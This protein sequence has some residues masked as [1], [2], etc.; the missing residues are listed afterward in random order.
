MK[1]GQMDMMAPA[2]IK[3]DL[4]LVERTDVPW[5]SF[6]FA[7]T[8]Q[9]STR[10]SSFTGYAS[11]PVKWFNILVEAAKLRMVMQPLVRQA[12]LKQG[13]AQGVMQIHDKYVTPADWTAS[14]AEYTTANTAIVPTTMDTFDGVV[15]DPEDEHYAINLTNKALRRNAND[16][17]RDAR[18]ELTERLSYVIDDAIFTAIRP[19]SGG[20]VT[21]MSN[22]AQGCQ[23]IFGGSATTAGDSL[24]VGDTLTTKMIRKS[25]KLLNTS[26]GRYWTS[27][28]FT[29]SAVAKNP[30]S[31]TP[32]GKYFA[33]ISS[34]DEEALTGQSQFNNA[35][36]F[37]DDKIVKEGYIGK[38]HGFDFVVSDL[39]ANYSSG[40]DVYVQGANT[41]VD[42]DCHEVYFVKA[43]YFAGLMWGLQPKWYVFD[44]P[45]QYQKNIQTEMAYKA[46][47]LHSDA[48]VR[49]IVADQ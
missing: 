8:Q 43:N 6:E 23:T 13:E 9:S 24:N 31:N 46:K 17:V 11:E 34:D 37:G 47:P 27:D 26:K 22:T 40:D 38:F 10:G 49:A 48:I 18:I 1:G 41:S 33:I 21:E 12:T 44:N 4:Q 42:I 3:I 2:G 30:W 5:R 16:K 32:D 14:V 25:K 45:K 39:L 20:A 7:A 19:L 36:Q 28:T 15:F 29:K 35:A